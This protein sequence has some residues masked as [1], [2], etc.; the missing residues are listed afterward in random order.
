VLSHHERWDG[1]G[2][3][4]GLTGNAIPLP[5]RVVAIADTYDAITA[6]R[7]YRDASP[8]D[9]ARDVIAQG[10]GSQFDPRLAA[11][12]LRDDVQRQVLHM[13]QQLA[14]ARPSPRGRRGGTSQKRV[15][16][17]TFR[18]RDGAGGPPPPDPESRTARE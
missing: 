17:V 10:Q 4:R 18:W 13:Q 1:R 7:S 11:V 15:P 8:L 9:R 3:P 16:D 6:R 2:Y 5:A 14:R 12:F